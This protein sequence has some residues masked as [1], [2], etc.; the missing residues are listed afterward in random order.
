MIRTLKV[1]TRSPFGSLGNRTVARRASWAGALAVVV[2]I[3]SLTAPAGASSRAAAVAQA[4]KSLIVRSDFPSGWTTSP[5]D[6]SN[7]TLGDAQ[8][9]A[10]LG[11]PVSVINYNPPSA[12][13]PEFDYASTDASVDDN[14]S[15]YPNEK[16][17]TQQYA[18]WSSARTPACFAKAFN[19]PSVK[20]TFEKQIGPGTVLGT[21][22]AR[23]L[24]KP[25]VGDQVTALELS[26]PFTA[27]GK[28]F[29]ISETQVIMIH[30]LLSAQLGFTTIDGMAIPATL[31]FHLESVT[32]QRLSR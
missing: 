15:V 4:R 9:A 29:V 3:G 28:S 20:R 24:P 8:V 5:S 14:V 22:T 1:P 17:L 31:E 2:T 10:C 12:Y 6:D 13:S 19:T 18:L 7:S 11:V 26:V 27:N 16:T 30:K 23:W 25:N 32:A 21:T